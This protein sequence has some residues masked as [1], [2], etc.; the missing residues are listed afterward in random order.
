MR[1]QFFNLFS[2]HFRLFK[3]IN[4]EANLNLEL[5]T[6]HLK[7]DDYKEKKNTFRPAY[8]QKTHYYLI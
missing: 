5:D 8:P 6:A 1:E 4:L 3:F 7:A 2:S